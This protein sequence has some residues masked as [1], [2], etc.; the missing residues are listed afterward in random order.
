MGIL[1]SLQVWM[2]S[3]PR[4][5]GTLT[6]L[7]S[8]Q[9]LSASCSHDPKEPPGRLCKKLWEPAAGKAGDHQESGLLFPY[10]QLPWTDCCLPLCHEPQPPCLPRHP[11]QEVSPSVTPQKTEAGRKG[12]LSTGTGSHR[13]PEC[14]L[15]NRQVS[16]S[17]CFLLW[18]RGLFH[19]RRH[20]KNSRIIPK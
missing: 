3:F 20:K 6:P 10:S 19:L 18:L 12:A 8:P 11:G 14:Q 15:G 5:T 9:H 1:S 7:T 17:Y 4:E 2:A 13:I 16:Q